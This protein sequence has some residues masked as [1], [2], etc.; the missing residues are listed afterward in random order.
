MWLKVMSLLILC[1]LSLGVQASP[2]GHSPVDK[3]ALSP[4]TPSPQ[5][6]IIKDSDLAD[7]LLSQALLCIKD[8]TSLPDVECCHIDTCS[9]LA[10]NTDKKTSLSLFNDS[11]PVLISWPK[12]PLSP[13]KKPPKIIL[14]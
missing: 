4:L 5:S 2:F 9:V 14:V 1:A 8:E 10:L 11:L 12:Q 6:V 7:T 13:L 3:T